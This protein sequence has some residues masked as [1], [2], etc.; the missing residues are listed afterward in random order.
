MSLSRLS[1]NIDALQEERWPLLQ[2]V[3]FM[4]LA[5]GF[6]FAG[7]Y[8]GLAAPAAAT[9]CAVATVRCGFI[10]RRLRGAP[11]PETEAEV[12]R[13][14]TLTFYL[15][16]T[17][18]AITT[19]GWGAPAVV[20]LV[21]VPMLATLLTD[22]RTGVLWTGLVANTILALYLTRLLGIELP[23]PLSPEAR[24]GLELVGNVAL[25]C[26]AMAVVGRYEYAHRRMVERLA[27]SG[28]DL[29]AARDHAEATSRAKSIFL[30]NMSH[31]VRTP[32]TAVI[33]M[34]DLLLA[35][36]Q[37]AEHRDRTETIRGSAESLIG[38]LNDILDF[39]KIESG[40]LSIEDVPFDPAE[41]LGDV[42]DLLA[43]RAAEKALELVLIAPGPLAVRGDP[44]R[45]RQI[46]MNLIGNAVKFTATGDVVVTL[47]VE[48]VP[49][50]PEHRVTMHLTVSDTGP[51]IPPESLGRLFEAFTQGDASTTRHF[52]GTGLGLSITRQLVEIMGGTVS[53]ESTL[54]S[55]SV[56]DVML[57]L[58]ELGA[59]E[60][61]ESASAPPEMHGPL[62]V[63]Y[64]EPH[65][66][67]RE[68]LA[69]ALSAIGVDAT[70]AVEPAD[71]VPPDG[72]NY[73]VV[74]WPEIWPRPEGL[75]GLGA[76]VLL[77]GVGVRLVLPP[78]VRGWLPKPIRRERL[79]RRLF[80]GHLL[81]VP[82]GPGTP[83][84]AAPILT[85]GRGLRILLAEDNPV[86]QRVM[87]SMLE[88]L[89]AGTMIVSDGAAAMKA[90]DEEAAFDLILMDGQMPG[91][92]G[93]TATRL[94]RGRT[95]AARDIPIVG[96]TAHAMA[97]DRERFLAVGMNDHLPKPVNLAT[98]ASLLARFGGDRLPTTAEFVT[99]SPA[100]DEIAAAAFAHHRATLEAACEASL[101][102]SGGE[103]AARTWRRLRS[104]ALWAERPDIAALAHRPPEEGPSEG[105]ARLSEIR[106]RP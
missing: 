82:S 76:E 70:L 19:G 45:F 105:L 71:G 48:R 59:H 86:N 61:S 33:G 90:L 28:E 66:I 89:G 69:G 56:F 43:P 1:L 80:R 26:L 54:G 75:G 22:L 77:V 7:V 34:A 104:A 29:R 27:Q 13:H 97:G 42:V 67:A 9:L 94:I 15:V 20:W 84:P 30:A 93:E 37:T 17:G 65:A 39:S 46:A 44:H 73:D 83:T 72:V 55:G 60:A 4:L 63:L 38:M 31:E 18:V 36:A 51:G 8:L 57:T 103:A 87:R 91:M 2:A 88:R 102:G 12:A 16:L 21:L 47:E 53:V 81:D 11:G 62:R 58:P 64:A 41:V 79:S 3:G 32:M 24:S 92:D 25:A 10:L 99:P 95:D 50:D 85:T 40:R 100:S 98:L 74:L 14:Y 6:L 106:R 78:G 52:G 5:T 96:V 49:A 68:A 23:S 35:G 101:D